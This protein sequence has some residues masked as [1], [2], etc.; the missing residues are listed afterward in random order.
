MTWGFE[1]H[2][3]RLSVR[4]REP[5]TD[6]TQMAIAAASFDPRVC[7]TVRRTYLIHRQN[8]LE[9][10]F[11]RVC[12]IS[13]YSPIPEV[14][15]QMEINRLTNVKDDLCAVKQYY[16][17]SAGPGAY[18]VEY[19]VPD[20]RNVNPLSVENLIMYPREGFGYNNKNIN[21]DSILRNQPGFL[22]KRCSTREQARPFLSVPYMGGGRGN[23]EVET[24]L[25]HSEYSRMGKACDT[26]T[27][28]F[29]SQQYTPLVPTLAA[30]IQDPKNLIPEDAAKGWIRGGLPSREYIRNVNC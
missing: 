5:N 22:S 18:A 30:S 12:P 25:Q 15:S 16:K 10:V 24:Q 2:L 9:R 6:F 28:T 11:R 8:R 23:A 7:F 19:L 4:P 20:A 3:N 17:Q 26:V 13:I 14:A 21:A 1:P 29:F 27:E